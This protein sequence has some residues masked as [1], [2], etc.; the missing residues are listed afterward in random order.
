M[1]PVAIKSA[2]G[3]GVLAATILV[4]GMAAFMGR[5]VSIA[6][7]AIQA[8]F[9]AAVSQ[10]QWV[11]T[12]YILVLATFTLISGRVCDAYG[13]RGV[14][15][16]GIVLFGAGALVAAVSGSMA[17]LIAS[18]AVLGLGGVLMLPA[19]LALINLTFADD[20]KG[21]AI[22]LWAG[23]GAAFGVLGLLTG[24][25]VVEAWGWRG[26]FRLLVPLAALAW[27]LARRSVPAVSLAGDRHIS[28]GSSLALA[29][30]LLGLAYALISGPGLGWGHPAVLAGGLLA[31]AAAVLFRRA[32]QAAPTPLIPHGFV[33]SSGVFWPDA[34][35][36]F[37]YFALNGLYVFL[38]I[39][40]QEVFGLPPSR[41]GMGLLP[42][43]LAVMLLTGW[44][45]RQAD[46]RGDK[47]FI[48]AGTGLTALGMAWVAAAPAGA[49]YLRHFLP[50]LLTVGL[51]MAL[52]V[53]PLTKLAVAVRAE[54]SGVASGLNN[55]VAR[56]SGLLAMALLGGVLATAFGQGL[57]MT[58]LTS[59]VA[60]A[61]EQQP[62][63]GAVVLP[64]GL[65]PDEGATVARLAAAARLGAYR[66]TMGV[67]AAFAGVS[68]LLS[69]ALLKG[70]GS[71]D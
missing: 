39:F 68:F 51:G 69:A 23:V 6:L 7:P 54:Y 41:A 70:G 35:T 55:T 3:A 45:G 9:G 27:A 19:C 66:W 49:T 63:L 15:L 29:V 20:Q 61:L 52:F 31:A 14:F 34:V 21:A 33:A 22:G 17:V 44:F 36:F 2:R 32:E 42:P 13:T 16:V 53:A 47:G 12:A 62:A 37:L 28:L 50:P 11:I 4:S 24:G 64:P 38:I 26:G 25:W 5:T 67:N 58:E 40:F 30:G 48:V 59:A 1:S 46:R 8:E 71:H 10:L 65:S 57:D 18:Q 56:V 60:L 43:S